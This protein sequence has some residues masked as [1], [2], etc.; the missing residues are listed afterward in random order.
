[1][2][3]KQIRRLSRQV[4]GEMNK[5]GKIPKHS[6]ACLIILLIGTSVTYLIDVN[7]Y[8]RKRARKEKQYNVDLK[9]AQEDIQAMFGKMCRAGTKVASLLAVPDIPAQPDLLKTYIDQSRPCHLSLISGTK[10]VSLCAKG[11]LPHR[12]ERIH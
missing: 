4:H 2:E 7:R 5:R 11:E 6:L 8:G 9:T 12:E 1:M 10:A 3:E